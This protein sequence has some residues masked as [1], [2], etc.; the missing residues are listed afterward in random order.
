MG[1]LKLTD[2]K[3]EKFKHNLIVFIIP[4]AI[5]YLGQIT[6]ALNLQG[7]VIDLADFTP[8]SATLGGMA[9]Y[10]MATLIDYKKKF[11]ESNP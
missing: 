1:A 6:A 3:F 8:S 11:D 7:N 4:L 9:Y 2:S 5:L 10:V